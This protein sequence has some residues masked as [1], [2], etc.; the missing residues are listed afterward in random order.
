MSSS[1]SS[2]DWV[3][4][5]WAHF[6]VHSRFLYVC[7]CHTLCPVIVTRCDGPDGLMRPV[8]NP[9]RHPKCIWNVNITFPI[10]Y[11]IKLPKIYSIKNLQ[12]LPTK[13]HIG[14]YT[15]QTKWWTIWMCVCV[16]HD[17]IRAAVRRVVR[18]GQCY[19]YRTT[20]HIGRW[21]QTSVTDNSQQ[22]SRSVCLSVCLSVCVS[23]S[24][25]ISFS[26]V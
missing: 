26:T 17:I 7:I 13:I 21:H 12:R 4:S 19:K 20:D 5:Y 16:V 10:S 15:N 11:F 6:T 1:Y 22:N 9:R 24:V 14:A 8:C 3:L 2:L 23:V 25:C 18:D